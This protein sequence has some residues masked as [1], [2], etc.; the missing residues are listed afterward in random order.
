M[1]GQLNG[2]VSTLGTYQAEISKM[3][4]DIALIQDN[5]KTMATKLSNR[6]QAY[7]LSRELLEG[8]TI[9]PDLIKFYSV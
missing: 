7:S 3:N 1:D 8:I 6:R 2:M 9:S 5:S 4:N